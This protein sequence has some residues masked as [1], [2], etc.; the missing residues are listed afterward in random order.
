MTQ[1]GLQNV[2]IK[3]LTKNILIIF[4]I[5]L[6]RYQSDLS[7][8]FRGFGPLRVVDG[9]RTGVSSEK[10]VFIYHLSKFLKWRYIIYE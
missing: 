4:L 10:N 2:D 6:F 5:A 3:Y 9:I 1:F 8:V 7:Q